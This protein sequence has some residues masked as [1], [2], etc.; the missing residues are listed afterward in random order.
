MSKVISF[1]ISDRYLDK[2]RTLYPAL[3]DN[4]AV[5][6]FVTDGLDSSLGNSLDVSLDDGLD[7]KLKT[8]IESSLSSSLDDTLDDVLDDKLKT[9]IE[10]SLDDVLDER[11]DAVMGKLIS[12]LSDRLSR[13]EARLDDSLDGSLDV[14]LDY[15]LPYQPSKDELTETQRRVLESR[16]LAEAKLKHAAYLVKNPLVV[17]DLS[18][19]Q[20]IETAIETVEAIDEPDKGAIGPVRGDSDSIEPGKGEIPTTHKAIAARLGIKSQTKLNYWIKTGTIPS[21]YAD[22]CRFNESKTKI[23]WII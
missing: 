5:K 2:L 20:P 3:T 9:I 14:K 18:K 21:E 10:T 17:R 15:G 4:L 12:S 6:Q 22:K 11:L 23:V 16:Q 19:K 13:L 8:L 7:D 1:S